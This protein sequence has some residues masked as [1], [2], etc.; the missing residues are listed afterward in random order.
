MRKKD[1][2]IDAV[3][4]RDPT[5]ARTQITIPR[6]VYLPLYKYHP[7]RYENLRVAKEVL[8]NPERIF[9][10]VRTHNEGGWCF[11]GRPKEWHIKE[12]MI[13]PF[14]DY[15]IFAV[16]VNQRLCLYESRAEV[17]AEDDPLSPKDWQNRYGALIWKKRTS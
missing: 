2:Q 11:T 5:N 8:Q 17:A 14:P 15:L 3:D 6:S 1:F 9:S 7:V 13:A 16:Y 4:P 12:K 10:G